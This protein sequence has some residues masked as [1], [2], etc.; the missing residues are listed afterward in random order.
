[1]PSPRYPTL[2]ADFAGRLAARLGLPSH[3]SLAVQGQ[4]PSQRTR[5]NSVQ[6]AAN[7]LSAY[8]VTGAVAQAPVLLVDDL[9]HSQWTLTV[10]G[11]L[12][13]RAGVEAVHPFALA[14]SQVG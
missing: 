1:V 9:V 10:A 2:V 3:V 6:Q 7:A 5:N 4:P 13:R 12:L 11:M 14:T 8:A